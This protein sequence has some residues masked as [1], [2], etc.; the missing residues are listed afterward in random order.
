MKNSILLVILLLCSNSLWAQKKSKYNTFDKGKTNS[1]IEWN[2]DLSYGNTLFIGD[3]RHN[4]SERYLPNLALS[5][6]FNREKD[7]KKGF[8]LAITAGKN[9]GE[10]DFIEPSFNRFFRSQ[11]LQGHIALRKALSKVSN[12]KTGNPLP[13]LHLIVGTGYYIADIRL[14]D[15]NESNLNPIRHET[16]GSLIFPIGLELS[17]FMKHSWGVVLSASN[18]IFS[19]DNI[20][21]YEVDSNGPDNQIMIN[22]GLCYKFN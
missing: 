13:Q 2:G 5:A 18:T 8:Q 10:S 20:D 3:L 19:K 15:P 14:F 17:Y 7:N 11:Y 22:L 6:R 4:S 9:S 21:L 12:E 16:V 1:K